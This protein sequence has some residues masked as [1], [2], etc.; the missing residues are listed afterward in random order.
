MHK[1]CKKCNIKKSFDEFYNTQNTKDGKRGKCKICT[2]EYN[3]SWKKNNRERVNYLASIDR[4]ENRD[5]WRVYWKNWRIKNIELNRNRQAVHEHNRRARLLDLK[6][7]F[8]T[9]EEIFE[10]DNYT[11]VYC[12]LKGTFGD[13]RP[14]HVIPIS[15][16]EAN[17]SN[18]KT[19]VVTACVKCNGAKG[20]KLLSEWLGFIEYNP[21]LHPK[22]R[23]K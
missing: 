9:K 8:W 2:D 23:N 14:D 10:R 12:G 19:N 13:F 6:T 17:P 20:F 21:K 11:C 1:I 16:L 18:L 22:F 5:K 4:E 7:E 15:R 3:N